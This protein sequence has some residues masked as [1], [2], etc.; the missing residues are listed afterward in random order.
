MPT[1][2]SKLLIGAVLALSSLLSV[3]PARSAESDQPLRDYLKDKA[4]AIS[5]LQQQDAAPTRLHAHVIAEGRSGV[6][7]LRVGDREQFQWLS[8]SPRQGAGFNLA[9]GSWESLVAMLSSAVADEYIV[10]AAVRGVPLDALDIVFTSIPERKNANLSYPNNLSYVAYI[11]SPA[12]D[13][14]LQALK[15]AVHANSSVIDLVTQPHQVSPLTIHY[16]Q[17]PAQRAPNTQPG[18]RE[19]ILEDQVPVT[20]GTLTS[21]KPRGEAQAPRTLIAHTRV[22]P[23]TGLRQ[24]WLGDDGYFSALHD[25]APGLLGRGLAPTVEENLLGVVTTCPTHI[26]EIQ[27]AA[28]GVLLDKLELTADAELSPRFGR[29]AKSPARYGYITYQVDVASPNSRADI[30]ALAK[31]VED[32]CPLYNL[33]KD[34]Q[35]LE[36]RIVH[37]PYVAGARG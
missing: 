1:V 10:Q 6:R 32:T 8:D 26:F 2:S 19:F 28:R 24:T 3:S 12:S 7:R 11:Q 25:S 15:A 36:G 5:A 29:N 13:A 35:K 23:H 14:E 16:Q 33:V 22:E 31:A 21:S 17:T 9:P 30:D 34:S 18:L 37:G 27:A 4:Q 20:K